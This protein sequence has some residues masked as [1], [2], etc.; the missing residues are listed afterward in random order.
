MSDLLARACETFVAPAA[1]RSRAE[2]CPPS[3]STAT[4]LASPDDAVPAAGAVAGELRRRAGAPAAVVCSWRATG[5]AG[6]AWPAA[7]ALARKLSARDQPAT[8]LGRVTWTRLPDDPAEA[9]AAFRRVVA[10]A[11]VPVVL[12]VAGPRPDALASLVAETDLAVVAP[13]PDADATVG[14]LAAAELR[15]M[16][17]PVTI[18]GAPAGPTARALARAGLARCGL[19]PASAVRRTA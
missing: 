9:G 13:P 1:E 11:E 15:A 16:G 5:H 14:E 10:A 2:A 4:V 6:T 7:A 3:W 17:L 19:D 12:A 18:V 8:A